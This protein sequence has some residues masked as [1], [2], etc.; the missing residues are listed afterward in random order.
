MAYPGR[1]APSPTGYLH[2]EHAL[3]FGHLRLHLF[4][5]RCAAVDVLQSLGTPHHENDE[6]VYPGTCRGKKWNGDP[7]VNWRASFCFTARSA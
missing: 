6:S 3:I 4:A 5:P 7:D 1:F 2:L